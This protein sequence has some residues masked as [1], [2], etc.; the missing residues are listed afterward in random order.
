MLKWDLSEGGS[1]EPPQRK[2]VRQET[3]PPRHSEG[4]SPSRCEKNGAS[5]D[6]PSETFGGRLSEPP[7]RKT[8][9]Q[10]TR[11]PR[12]SEGG[13]P[14]RRKENGASRRRALRD[15]RRAAL[16]AAAKKNGA[17]GERTLRDIRRAA[18]LSRRKEKRC[19]RRTHPPRHSEG[20]SLEPP[21]R[22]TV[23]QE[24]APSET[25]GGRLS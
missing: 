5:G 23:R 10:E 24:N 22:K 1:L 4:G 14:S 3:R 8:V 2:T 7:Q 19:V 21:Q 12:H 25:F 9:R 20:G 13:S 17:S 18:L 16:R 6:A 11:P 15:I